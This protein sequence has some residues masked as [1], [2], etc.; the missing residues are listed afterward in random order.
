MNLAALVLRLVIFLF[1][2]SLYTLTL[3]N[4]QPD[5]QVTTG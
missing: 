5:T 1:I 3:D 4:T 2:V